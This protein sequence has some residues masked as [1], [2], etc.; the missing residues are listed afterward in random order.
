MTHA[1]PASGDFDQHVEQAKRTMRPWL[2]P[3]ARVGY[4]AKGVVYLL[5]G[6]LAFRAAFGSSRSGSAEAS[7]HNVLL[8]IASQPF[9]RFL[10]TA[11]AVG[12]LAYALWKIIEATFD[13]ENE[14]KNLKG[15]GK[16]L[17]RLAS[18]LIY[19]A[20][21]VAAASM[22]IG[23]RAGNPDAIQDWTRWGMSKPFGKTLVALA[24]LGVVAKG[25]QQL[26]KAWR[27]D[28]PDQLQLYRMNHEPR[29]WAVRVGR[30]GIAS[31][32]VTFL[33]IG[34]FLFLA[35]WHANPNEAKGLGASLQYLERAPYGPWLLG[36][37]ALG[38]IAYG[39]F[40][41]IESKYRQFRPPT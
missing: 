12:L 36:L 20:L 32:G 8:L 39:L 2:P 21:G 3:A 25:L 6:F 34:A 26:W 37:V 4:A 23:L 33:V 24:G 35:A 17:A 18:G 40:N 30:A 19:G 27:S 29:Q 13:P 7:K 38:L 41:L 16:R 31:R 15:Y 10:L 9:G 11:V 1:A 5:V 14:P 22:A 28:L